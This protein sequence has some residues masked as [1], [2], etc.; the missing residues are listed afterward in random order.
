M[1]FW[2]FI[3]K[4]RH[5]FRIILWIYHKYLFWCLLWFIIECFISSLKVLKVCCFVVSA[6]SIGHYFWCLDDLVLGVGWFLL[7]LLLLVARINLIQLLAWRSW[8]ILVWV[9]KLKL[10][11]C[12]FIEYLILILKI[13]WLLTWYRLFNTLILYKCRRRLFE[14]SDR[15]I[16]ILAHRLS[17]SII[18]LQSCISL[19]YHIW[20]LC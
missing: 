11:M 4:R 10:L 18:P 8:R 17:L 2:L 6:V 14:T 3:H 15:R 19:C 13:N 12:I 1:Y 7:L 9:I 20:V 16:W 5:L